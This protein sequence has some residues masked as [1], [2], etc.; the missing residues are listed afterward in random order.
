MRSGSL[1]TAIGFSP[2]FLQCSVFRQSVSLSLSR[3]LS[4]ASLIGG[5]RLPFCTVR[6][7]KIWHNSISLPI[8]RRFLAALL[9][10]QPS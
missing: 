10:S 5:I 4:G 9:T 7:G 8:P 6:G 2:S 3:S 1:N